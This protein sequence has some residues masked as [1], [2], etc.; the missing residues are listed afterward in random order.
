MTPL[1]LTEMQKLFESMSNTKHYQ[2]RIY[3]AI[4]GIR[5]LSSSSLLL[6]IIFNLYKLF[7]T[8]ISMGLCCF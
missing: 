3:E 1:W 5:P 7:F 8:K 4:N 6:Q 2:N